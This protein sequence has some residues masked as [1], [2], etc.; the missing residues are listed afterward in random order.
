M[1]QIILIIAFIVSGVIAIASIV[2]AVFIYKV[3]ISTSSFSEFM[4][5]LKTQG[6]LK[7]LFRFDRLVSPKILQFF[8][9]LNALGVLGSALILLILSLIFGITQLDIRLIVGGIIGSVVLAIAGEI[10]LRIGYEIAILF[11]KMNES[12]SVLKEV[13][14]KRGF[15]EETEDDRMAAEALADTFNSIKGTIKGNQT[16]APAVKVCPNCGTQNKPDAKFC[17]GCGTAF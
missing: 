15:I 14:I 17:K 16:T 9:G 5:M 4:G 3:Y 6:Y 2:G 12:L 11:F 1:S 10:F 13:Q 7:S 8:Y